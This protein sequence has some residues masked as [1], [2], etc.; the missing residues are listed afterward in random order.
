MT[1]LP[2][3]PS[4]SVRSFGMIPLLAALLLSAG[5]AGLKLGGAASAPAAPGDSGSITSHAP[6]ALQAQRA[7]LADALDSAGASVLVMPDGQLQIN[8]PSDF[9]FGSDRAEIRAEGRPVLDKVAA[10][11][12]KPEFVAMRVRV[13]GHTDSQGDEAH[14]DALSLARANSVRRHLEAKGVAAARLQAVGRGE[15]EPLAPNDKDYGRALNRR[16]EIYLQTPG[17]AP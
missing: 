7:A 15:R 9:S 1:P 6:P 4:P 8:V 14:N 5:C 16:I 12:L 11:L 17:A 13:V 3:I 2:W 10:S